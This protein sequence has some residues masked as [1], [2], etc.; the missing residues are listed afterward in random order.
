MLVLLALCV[1]FS[2]IITPVF[3]DDQRV[4][5]PVAG[6]TAGDGS[7][8][9]SEENYQKME[10]F[11][12]EIDDQLE[13]SDDK[14]D[15][16]GVDFEYFR[17]KYGDEIVD[18]AISQIDSINEEA[19]NGDININKDGTIGE[20]GPLYAGSKKKVN[21]N[22]AKTYW[23]GRQIWQSYSR[24]N[25]HKNDLKNCRTINEVLASL[26]TIGG[27]T[28]RFSVDGVLA[29]GIH[30]YVNKWIK[31]FN[32]YNKKGKGVKYKIYWTCNYKMATQGTSY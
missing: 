32:K 17:D 12:E 29:L 5:D 18:S 23:W 15:M 9:L 8:E 19:E 14:V 31:S 13:F 16:S 20:S 7:G 25:K 1:A 26:C 28:G 22:K 10:N 4:E 2:V 11:I 27:L 3:A 6:Y 30:A 24:A 21:I